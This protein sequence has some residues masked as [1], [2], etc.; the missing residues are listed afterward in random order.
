MKPDKVIRDKVYVDINVFY[1]YLRPDPVHLS[2]IRAFLGRMVQGEIGVY[3]S[4]LTMDELFYRL[5][6]ARVKDVYGRNPLNVLRE[7]MSGAIAR[8]GPEIKVALRRLVGLPHL[9]LAAVVED[10]FPQ[11]LANITVFGLL[12]RDALHVTVMQRLGLSEIATDDAD[13]DRVTWL[14]RHWVFNVPAPV[15]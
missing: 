2:T 13:F 9:Q 10:D 4:V 11:M 14:Q 12:P 8:C 6:L 15:P 5:L 1:M 7:D 3:T